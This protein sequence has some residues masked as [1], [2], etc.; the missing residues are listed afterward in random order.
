MV[1]VRIDQGNLTSS[2]MRDLAKI[3]REAGDGCLR[4][5]IDQNL[6]LGFVPLASCRV[7]TRR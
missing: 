4:V 6:V 1:T 5:T 7:C 3:A 2:Q